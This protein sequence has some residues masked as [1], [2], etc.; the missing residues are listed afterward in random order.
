MRKHAR[1]RTQD[2]Q[3]APAVV[4]HR[5]EHPGP[6]APCGERERGREREGCDARGE[7][8]GRVEKG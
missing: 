4:A 6:K 1:G 3:H 7:A 5:Q 8:V 2:K